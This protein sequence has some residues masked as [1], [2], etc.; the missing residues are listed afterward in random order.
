MGLERFWTFGVLLT[1][2]SASS[3]SI[4]DLH[5]ASDAIL[6]T[7]VDLRAS[8]DLHLGPRRPLL[9]LDHLISDPSFCGLGRLHLGPRRPLLALDHMI[10]DPSF[11]GLCRL[12][13][14]LL[15]VL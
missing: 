1:G 8:V 6:S 2:P 13:L 3:V 11:C 4:L 10:S 5:M 14:G 9:A 7:Y 15:G 12:H